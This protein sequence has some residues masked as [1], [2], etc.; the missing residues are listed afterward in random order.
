MRIVITGSI[1]AGKSTVITRL[2]TLL[3]GYFVVSADGLVRELY[4]HNE[5]FRE[6]LRQRFGTVDRKEISALV[7]TGAH[8][9]NGAREWLAN[10]SL[11]HL[12]P[13]VDALFEKK[14]LIFEFPLFFE[15]PR[16]AQKADEVIML[17]CPE[18][19]RRERV[20][21]RDNIT[22]EMFDRIQGNQLPDEVKRALAHRV[23][24]TGYSREEVEGQ[25]E[26]L[27]ATILAETL[28]RRCDSFFQSDQV[29]PL[30]AAAYGQPHREYHTI[31][32]LQELFV[33]LDAIRGTAATNFGY[34][35]AIELAVWFHDFVYET[36]AQLYPHNEV[37][38]A[39]EMVRVTRQHCSP[40]WQAFM[41]E[42][43]ILACLMVTATK[44]H[45]VPDYLA[46]NAEQADALKLFL[47]AD[48]AILA[49]S[50]DRLEAYDKGVRREWLCR[51]HS[52][53]DEEF[54]RGRH[55]ALTA[56]AQREPI[57]YSPQFKHLEPIAKNNLEA[58]KQKY[59]S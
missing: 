22:D 40:T 53:S 15:Y 28:H 9:D 1:G 5:A 20:K 44:T 6:E 55:A 32:H 2:V 58:L 16:W 50:P 52:W 57:F 39:Q 41:T 26:R 48:L 24:F 33:Q 43:L 19:I 49:A 29:W 30:V 27:A 51:I 10:L 45:K 38:S 21:A 8:A 35:S 42:Q 25:V 14:N 18:A 13:V 46:K 56:L 12:A 59:A 37:Y 34:W 17:D 4:A 3:P 31:R 54:R 23:V 36:D 7:L 47:D 11:V